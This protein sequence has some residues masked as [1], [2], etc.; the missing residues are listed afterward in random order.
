MKTVIDTNAGTN[1]RDRRQNTINLSPFYS[2]ASEHDSQHH[3]VPNPYG[4]Y[5]MKLKE[6]HDNFRV[7][8]IFVFLNKNNHFP[9]VV[10]SER[11]NK[12]A[13][14]SEHRA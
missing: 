5:G 10:F 4:T 6:H 3:L 13:S 7:F 8:D 14:S 12:L 11:S 2:I 9:A 1:L